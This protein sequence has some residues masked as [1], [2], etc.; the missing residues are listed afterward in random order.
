M[1]EIKIE[2]KVYETPEI[3]E[4]GDIRTLTA[5]YSCPGGIDAMYFVSDINILEFQGDGCGPGGAVS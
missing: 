1:K 5:G 3:V 2:H 4:F